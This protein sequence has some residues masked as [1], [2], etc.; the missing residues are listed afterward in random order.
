MNKP[1]LVGEQNP[2]G[3]DP[4]F[5]L[6]PA[7]EG[8]SGHR[9]CCLVLKMRRTDYLREFERVNLCDGGWNMR[10]ARVRARKLRAWGA[11]VVLLGAKVARA[12]E[13]HPFRP[14]TVLDDGKVLVLPHPSGLCRTW[15][16]SGAFE[17]ARALVTSVAPG[18][19][20]L[21][22]ASIEHMGGNS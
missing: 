22:G 14:F 16:E 13:F 20:H 18:V 7:P 17:R 19:A 1:L 9:L 12:F 8:C 10:E 5:A 4:Q 15:N 3:G 21:I 6:Y 2:Y 11:P